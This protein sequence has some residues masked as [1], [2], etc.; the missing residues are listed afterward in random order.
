MSDLLYFDAFARIG[1]RREKHLAEAWRLEELLGEM[2]HC[3]I[4]GALVSSTRSV[5]Y[6][7]NYG[8]L[9][10]SAALSEHPH[11]FA[12]WNVMPHATGEFPAPDELGRSMREHDVRAV[13]VYPRTNAWDPEAEHSRGLLGWLE[14]ERI[15]TILERHEFDH[16]RELDRL[17]ARHP[18]LPLL[19][20]KAANSELRF[21][22]PLL[23]KYPAL[24]IS[25]DLFHMHYGPEYLVDRGLEDQLVFG[26]NA[27]K[28]SMGAHRTYVDYAEIPETARAKIAGG[29]LARLL[30]GQK[31]PSLVSNSDEDELMAAARRGQPLP[32]PVI[33]MHMHVLHEGLNGAGSSC[34]MQR[35]GPEGIFHLAGRLGYRGGGIMS[36]NGPLGDSRT[37]NRLLAEVMDAAPAGYWGLPTF[38][39][40]HFTQDELKTVIPEV[41]ADGRFIGM[42][43][44]HYYPLDYSH[45]CYDVWWKYGDE[46]G[47]YAIID[48]NYTDDFRE[49]E[50]LAE[51]YPRVRWVAAHTG[52]DFDRADKAAELIRKFDNVYVEIC[53]SSVPLGMID[54]LVDGCGADR[55]LYGTDMPVLDPRQPLGW[56]VF[57][58]LPLEDKRKV[59]GGNALS[60]IRPCASRLPSHHR[61]PGL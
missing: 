14:R 26:T 40:T 6:D 1:P 18:E 55:V 32:A 57:S 9:G 43:P 50:S 49:V 23:E 56:V 15:L 13:T 58:R 16:Y 42:K 59:L 29:N 47:L 10:L 25:F 3:S 17:L 36:M 61:P 34:P 4:S 20:V 54:Y 19:L 60:V 39:T 12:A 30:K 2:Q 44:Y 48:R 35:G 31:P 27:P 7:P 33:D 8:N 5:H 53:L 45:P 38:D 51:R 52:K 11:L 41:Y 22:L 21:V 28:M 24:H 46:H 37:G